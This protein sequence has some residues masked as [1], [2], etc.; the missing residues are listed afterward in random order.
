MT[1]KLLN[2]VHFVTS[3]ENTGPE[4]GGLGEF[5]H[6]HALWASV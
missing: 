6:F 2:F 3:F 1:F 5:I 4:D